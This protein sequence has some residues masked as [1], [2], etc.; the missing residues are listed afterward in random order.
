MLAYAS[1]VLAGKMVAGPHVRNA[2]RRHLDD[3]QRGGERGLTWDLEAAHRAIDFFPDVLRLAQGKFEGMPFELEPAQQFIIG[4]IFGWKRADGFRRFRR[5]YIEM[6]KGGGKALALD[7]AIP[8]PGGWTTM[9]ELRAGDEVLDDAGRPC[10]VLQAHPVQS[11]RPCYRV[12]FDDGAI[13]VA[14]AEHLWMTEQRR[15]DTPKG[16]SALSGVPRS[17]Q[18]AWRQGVRSTRKI[19]E[20]LRYSNGRYRSANHSIRLAAPL[21]LP[22]A[23]LPIEPYT[24]GVWLGDGDSDCARVTVGDADVEI[25]EHLRTAGTTVGGRQGG[26]RPGRYLLGGR[27]P[28]CVRGHAPEERIGQKCRACERECDRARRRGVAAPPRTR[29][30]ALREKLR[31]AGLLGNKHIPALYLRASAAQRLA[32][33]QGIMDT[34]GHVSGRGCCELD[35]TCRPLAE[36]ARELAM[37][38]GLKVNWQEGRA[39]LYGRDVGPRYRIQFNA[40]DAMRVFRL[41]RKDARQRVPHARRRLSA[42]RRVV[43]CDPVESVSVRCISVDSPT[44]MY[45]A[46]REFIPTHNSPMAGGVGMYCLLADGEAQAE[47]YA[48]ASMK[49]QAMVIFRAAVMMWRQSPALGQRLVPSGGN[50]IWQLSDMKRGGFFRPI[51]TE[52][53]HSGP[54]PSCALLDE[55]HEHRD[56]N[57]VEMLERGFKSRRQPLLV[58]I[59]NS[60]SDRQSVCWQEHL[61][62]VRVAAGTMVPDDEY[63]YVG[64]VLDGGDATFSYV[65]ALDKGDDPLEDERCWIKA[66]PLLGITMPAAEI[67]SAVSQARAIPGKL[68]NILRLHFCVWTE[69]DTAWMGRKALERV[70]SDFDPRA[71]TG[72]GVH[73]GLDLSGSQ[74]LTAA[75]FVV[76]T[77]VKEVERDGKTV[78][79]PTFDAWVEAWTPADTMTERALRDQAPY[80]EWVRAGW[81]HSVPGKIIRLGFLAARLAEINREY[82]IRLVAYDRYSYRKL[83]E[84]MDDIGLTLPQAEHPQG[85]VRRAKPTQDQIDEAKLQGDDPPLG[86]WMP[87]SVLALEELILEERIR[88][89]NS[90]LL[91]WACM[92]A[93]METDAFNNRWFSKKRAVNRIDPLVALA[94]GVGSATSRASKV[95]Q[96]GPSYEGRGLLFL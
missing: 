33:L 15:S 9:G 59:T 91:V 86:L 25:L 95:T 5:A 96:A 6:A 79:L 80:H 54:M 75:A 44:Q 7:T 3:L 78:A 61:W 83:E 31:V 60:G 84:E 20:T 40:P 35:L 85:G 65:C 87:G 73:I 24:L 26:D 38:L 16:R 17:G 62:A 90:P 2:C 94:M 67:R 68:N 93:A 11:G 19:A 13:I 4:S 81:L 27:P 29:E 8:T 52:E 47:V 56:S 58:M 50:P 48:G 21:D 1:N 63:T 64:D 23:A 82:Q 10:R 89:L 30:T 77:G 49:S 51:S 72:M 43:A 53:A 32:L 37:S 45:L 74:D 92:S 69:S 66:N 55:I 12:E 28:G 42:D 36:G 57:M 88:L 46:G 41:S 71:Y 14:D 70:L 76:E 22:P 39:T 34:D 18:G